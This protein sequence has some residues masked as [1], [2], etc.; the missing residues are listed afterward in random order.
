M[1]DADIHATL[2]FLGN[3]ESPICDKLICDMNS[4]RDVPSF[5]YVIDQLVLFPSARRPRVIAAAIQDNKSLHSL[6]ARLEDI[7]CALGF[8]PEERRYRGHITLGRLGKAADLGAAE[9]G[10][11]S[12]MTCLASEILLFK[13]DPNSAGP[14]YSPVHSVPLRV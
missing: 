4:L 13:S 1:H 10:A 14:I 9:L 5:T 6:I 8:K 12:A 3:T 11:F 7:V 2:R